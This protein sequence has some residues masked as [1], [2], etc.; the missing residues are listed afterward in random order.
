MVTTQATCLLVSAQQK[1]LQRRGSHA[2][3]QPGA[4]LLSY[5]AVGKGASDNGTSEPSSAGRAA[6]G[7]PGGGIWCV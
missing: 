4:A 1:T 7:G 6:R 5:A 3:A 2:K